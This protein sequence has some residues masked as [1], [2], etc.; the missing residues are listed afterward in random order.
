MA[1]TAQTL[2]IT[3]NSG[4]VTIDSGTGI[5]R[6]IPKNGVILRRSE[7]KFYLENGGDNMREL[8]RMVYGTDTITIDTV[9]PASADAM[10]TALEAVLFQ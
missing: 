1:N 5:S 7:D 4:Y 6:H 3:G 8:I 2:T 10:E 9:A